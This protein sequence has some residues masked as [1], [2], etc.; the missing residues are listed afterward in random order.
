LILQK[1]F[2]FLQ[3]HASNKFVIPEFIK[4]D[5]EKLYE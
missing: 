5:T 4:A 3:T 2:C 1:Y